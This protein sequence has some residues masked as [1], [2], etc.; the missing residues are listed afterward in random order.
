MCQINGTEE[1]LNLSYSTIY[2]CEKWDLRLT[3]LNMA[4]GQHVL[5]RCWQHIGD[6]TN[7]EEFSY[8]FGAINA[9]IHAV[10]LKSST[11]FVLQILLVYSMENSSLISSQFQR[12]L[13]LPTTRRKSAM[14]EAGSIGPKNFEL[15]QTDH[16]SQTLKLSKTE[17]LAS[18]RTK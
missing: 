9:R 14:T 18:H 17:H 7:I 10:D 1:T 6:V 11:S 3:A 2:C 12:G 13:L 5:T 16:C 4:S 15:S 8:Y